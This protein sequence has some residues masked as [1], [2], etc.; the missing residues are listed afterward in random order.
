MNEVDRINIE[1]LWSLNQPIAKI[2]AVHTGECES[3]KANSD[4]AKELEAELLLAKELR[5][6][7]TANIW[8]EGNLVNSAMGIIQ[9]ILFEDQGP[10]SLPTAVFIK[11]NIYK[12]SNITTLKE[13]KVVPIVLI[14]RSWEGKNGS[15]T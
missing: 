11:F 4:T 2:H 3:K 6:M 5:V 8:T 15:C 13:D 9:D 12:E 7:L 14:K 10:P 1:M